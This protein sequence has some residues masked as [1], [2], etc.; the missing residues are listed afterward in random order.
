MEN[1]EETILDI[2]DALPFEDD[3]RLSGEALG[4]VSAVFLAGVEDDMFEVWIKAVRDTR[5]H[6]RRGNM[7]KN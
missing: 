2:I 1:L 6:I 7:V 4:R 3:P 5:D